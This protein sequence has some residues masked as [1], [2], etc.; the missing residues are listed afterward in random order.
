[1]C[2]PRLCTDITQDQNA[3]FQAV[4]GVPTTALPPPTATTNGSSCG[5]L[6][7]SPFCNNERWLA[8]P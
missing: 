3:D 4:R 8:M 2:E 6:H 5:P 7:A 1:M